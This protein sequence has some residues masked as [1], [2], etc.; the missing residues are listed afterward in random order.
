MKW[1]VLIIMLLVSNTAFADITKTLNFEEEDGVPTTFPYKVKV[2][3]GSLTDNADGTISLASSGG[4]PGTPTSSIQFN[5]ASTFGGDQALVWDSV[6]NTLS[7]SR[8]VSQTGYALVI[9]SDISGTVLANI[10]HDGTAMVKTLQVGTAPTDTI[11]LGGSKG[12]VMSGDAGG[13]S[14]TGTGNT[15]NEKINIDLE[16]NSNFAILT[17]PTGVTQFQFS[18]IAPQLRDDLNILFGNSNDAQFQFDAAETNDS[19]KLGLVLGASTSSGNLVISETADINTNFGVAI[20]SDPT[21]V[22]QGAD[23]TQ[24][25]ERGR[26]WYDSTVNRFIVSTDTGALQLGASS[27]IVSM[28]GQSAGTMQLNIF[29]TNGGCIM[30]RDTDSAGYTE[31]DALNGALSCSIDADGVCD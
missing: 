25:A 17:S 22:M 29:G 19:M 31:C 3:N 20:A 21:I 1:A 6:A 15:N 4:S 30:L 18:G 28:D 7:I 2:A 10:S 27:R 24:T 26:L 11:T 8:D 16:S 12:I 13:I 23:A 9:S 14:F 5:N